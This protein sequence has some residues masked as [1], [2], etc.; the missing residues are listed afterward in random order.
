V[1]LWFID[2]ATTIYSLSHS[3]DSI[4]FSIYAWLPSSLPTVGLFRFSFKKKSGL[5]YN[6]ISN[7]SSRTEEQ[8]PPSSNDGIDFE[9]LLDHFMTVQSKHEAYRRKSQLARETYLTW[10]GKK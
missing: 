2:A 9:S 1:S 4:G 3:Q 10:K 5:T 8:Q 7:C 6:M